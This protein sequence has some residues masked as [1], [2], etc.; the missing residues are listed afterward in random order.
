MESIKIQIIRGRPYNPHSQGSVERLH[1][2]LKKAIF[3]IYSE[4][5]KKKFNI[6][7]AILTVCNN[8]NNKKHSAT[9]YTP[10]SIFISDNRNI[11]NNVINNIKKKYKS[12][13]KV[14]NLFLPNEKVLLNAKFIKIKK[15]KNSKGLA[16]LKYKEIK[17][18][19]IYDKICAIIIKKIS[20]DTYHIK[21]GK[22]YSKFDLMFNVEFIVSSFQ[23]KK[24]KPETWDKLIKEN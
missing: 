1:Q 4:N 15:G 3:A 18:Q 10:F 20:V 24:C 16:L 12:E 5:K 17:N 2:T 22:N 6:K 23:L 9:G 8:Y 13:E 7:D 19:N 14:N 21:I 11:F